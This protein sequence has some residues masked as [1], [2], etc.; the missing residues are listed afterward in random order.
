MQR[1]N[2]YFLGIKG[3]GMSGLAA[4]CFDKGYNVV[5]SDTEQWF[6]SQVNLD[7][8]GIEMLAFDENNI[9]K[10]VDYTFICGDAFNENNNIEMKYIIDNNLNY[11]RYHDFVGLLTK[12]VFSVGIAGCHGKTSTT[13]MFNLALQTQK[14]VQYI[15]GDGSG[16]GLE[17]PDIFLVEADEYRNH[18][19]NYNF[20]YS[21]VT[22]IDFDHPDF[23][24]SIDDMCF[25]FET[26]I[27]NTHQKAIVW[28][29]DKYIHTLD[30]QKDKLVTYG[31]EDKNDFVVNITDTNNDGTTFTILHNDE[32][33]TNATLP[34]FGKH[35]ILNA[36][37]CIVFC[38]LNNLNIDEAVQNLKNYK[39]PK[40]RFDIY[41]IN[42][43][44]LV[45]D[46]AHHPAEIKSVYDSIK[47]K[48]AN[49]GKE[50]IAVHMPF[51]YSRTK[52]LFSGFV[53]SLELFD[54]AYITPIYASPRENVKT[55]DEKELI[56]AIPD[57]ELITLNSIFNL[58]K[59]ANAVIAFMSCGNIK[60]Y[61]EVYREYMNGKK[62]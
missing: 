31:F 38:Y 30:V 7:K 37:S 26:F 28:G 5:G 45:D 35:M 56:E 11:L 24:N 39:T 2:L 16:K 48:Y 25:T 15:I 6:F 13:N 34:L 47:Q 61:V 53:E 22:N 44:V 42:D 43:Q 23:F 46:Y 62:D 40:R 17:K 27:N 10:Y 54:K 59:H 29:E 19:L 57:A 50:I 41:E 52:S 4:L 55:I 12:Q 14:E 1:K 33:I 21:I 58:E 49:T 51:T 3:S 8:R 20:E 18:F 36:A 60:E 32:L 9:K